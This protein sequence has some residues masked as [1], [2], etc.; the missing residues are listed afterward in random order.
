MFRI[1]VLVVVVDVTSGDDTIG[2]VIVKDC[3][4]AELQRH[5]QPLSAGVNALW[6]YIGTSLSLDEHTS[7]T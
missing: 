4:V 6:L 1:G 3:R 5:F 7:H 2:D